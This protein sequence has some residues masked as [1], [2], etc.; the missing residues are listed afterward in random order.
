MHHLVSSLGNLPCTINQG[1]KI[2]TVVSLDV[3]KGCVVTNAC[4]AKEANGLPFVE[5]LCI[6]DDRSDESMFLEAPARSITV[7]VGPGDTHASRRLKDPADVRRFLRLI[8]DQNVQFSGD[9]SEIVIEQVSVPPALKSGDEAKFAPPS[10]ASANAEPPAMLAT[11]E[12]YYTI[13]RD[14]LAEGDA[15]EHDNSFDGLGETEM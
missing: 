1:K 6:G 13:G 12:K 11:S 2:I 14:P 4:R 8:V 7:K 15:P 5:V 9:A 10:R 3:N